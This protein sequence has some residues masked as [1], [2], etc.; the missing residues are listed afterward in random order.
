[1]FD[2]FSVDLDSADIDIAAGTVPA[3]WHQVGEADFIDLLRS[4]FSIQLPTA[5]TR[6]MSSL[7]QREIATEMSVS[8]KS[9]LG[10]IARSPKSQGAVG[11]FDHGPHLMEARRAHNELSVCRERTRSGRRS[12]CDR[13]GDRARRRGGA[14]PQLFGVTCCRRALRRAESRD[15]RCRRV[16][17]RGWG[18]PRRPATRPSAMIVRRCR[19]GLPRFTEEE[20]GGA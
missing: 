20:R 6:V 3:A 19:Q 15:S 12:C 10:P 13:A 14:G 11:E 18:S 5:T 16:S 8:L 2:R 4:G 17:S 7:I 9:P 1:M